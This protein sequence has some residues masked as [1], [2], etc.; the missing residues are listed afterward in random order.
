MIFGVLA[1]LCMPVFMSQG[2]RE[3][4]QQKVEE[5]YTQNKVGLRLSKGI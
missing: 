5:T 1:S 2:I 3:S 4:W